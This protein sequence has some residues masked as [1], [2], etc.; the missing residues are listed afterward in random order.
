MPYPQKHP[1]RS[2]TDQEERALSQLAKASSERVDTVRRAKAVLAVNA[3]KPFTVAAGLSGFKS[4]DSVS[5]LVQRFNQ[6][7]LAALTIAHG[8][9]RKPTYTSS[10]RQRILEQLRNAPNREQDQSAT[11]SLRLLQRTLR[12][13][14]L[15]RIGASTIRRILHK[16]GYVFG[17]SRTVTVH[18]PQAQEKQHLIE[19]AYH[20]AEEA[21]V[22][23]WCQDEAGPYQ[24]IPQPGEDWHLQG[25]P[26]RLPHEYARGGTAKLLTLFRPA[27]GQVHATGVLSAPNAVLHP[28][29]KEELTKILKP[30]LL[31]EVEMGRPAE[32]ERPLGA[33]WRTWLWPHENDE[34]LPPLRILLVWDNL[35]GHLSHDLFPWL[36]GNGIMPLYTPLGGSWLNMAESVQR[37]IV[38]RALAGQHPQSAQQVIDWLEQTVAGWNADPTS[39][40]WGGKRHARRER[41]RLRR[42]G[43]S[44]AALVKG[45][46]IAA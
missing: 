32:S 41:A 31:R 6:Q 12:Q 36:F 20:I 2:L 33:R 37:I 16:T 25:Y 23:L 17:R 26:R 40:V 9:G 18:D 22:E 11:W 5:Q 45:Y 10:Q 4:A 13:H 28:W 27:T 24:A 42:L 21:G 46:S 43:G 35:A 19:L 8:R 29:L 39:F 14:L 44:G 7:G 3:G 34:G 15:P 30:I 1:L 38:R